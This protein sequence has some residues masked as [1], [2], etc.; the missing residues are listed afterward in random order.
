MRPVYSVVMSDNV[1]I[2]VGQESREFLVPRSV[3]ISCS[4]YFGERLD[5]TG[6]L[7]HHNAQLNTIWLEDQCPEMFE[8]FVYWLRQRRD[9]QGHI[10]EARRY[11]CCEDLHWDLV[12][13]HLFAAQLDIVALQDAAMDGI[14]DLHLLCNWDISERLV[15][16]VYT[17]CDPET[18]CRLR[19]WIVAMTAWSLGGGIEKI[20]TAQK[21]EQLFRTCPD[22]WSEYVAHLSKISKTRIQLQLKNPQLRLP[23]NSFRNEERQF[24][25]RQ[26]SFHTHR[27][28]VKDGRCPHVK[29]VP[30]SPISRSPVSDESSS[31]SESES[32]TKA[33][34]FPRSP[35]SSIFELYLGLP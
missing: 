1:Q 24:G 30:H 29:P 4:P 3:L 7:K 35:M 25:F 11:D 18:S 16:H 34:H 10:D 20:G 27:S 2:F 28:R 33:T 22:F 21:M 9:F 8:L 12:N 13:L 26:C 17:A 14:Q 23:S 19:K 6:V 15:E 32:Y 5:A 31:E